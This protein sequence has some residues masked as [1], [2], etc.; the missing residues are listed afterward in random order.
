MFCMYRIMVFFLG[1]LCGKN[2]SFHAVK[3]GSPRLPNAKC[4]NPVNFRK[5]LGNYFIIEIKY[6]IFICI[7]QVIITLFL[8]SVHS[9][10]PSLQIVRKFVHLLDQSD[11][12]YTEEIGNGRLFLFLKWLIVFFCF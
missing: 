9:D 12:D 4:V 2:P 6:I 8:L 7:M 3:L 11:L 10:R 1:K 5:C